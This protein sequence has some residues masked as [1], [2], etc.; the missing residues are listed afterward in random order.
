[1]NA[2][3]KYQ[4]QLMGAAGSVFVGQDSVTL[5]PDRLP[6][7]S[8][9]NPKGNAQS[10]IKSKGRV[11][12]FLRRGSAEKHTPPCTGILGSLWDG[13]QDSEIPEARPREPGRGGGH[14]GLWPCL[15][16]VFLCWAGNG[17][18]AGVAELPQGL[19]CSSGRGHPHLWDGKTPAS[20]MGT[21]PPLGG[22]S[23][24][25]AREIVLLPC[26]LQSSLLERRVDCATP[27]VSSSRGKLSRASFRALFWEGSA[28]S[29]S[30][31]SHL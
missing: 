3:V 8:L 10:V 30:C 13:L 20:G 18:R 7:F 17:A 26:L 28:G 16:S 23:L 14:R 25:T 12:F 21:L 27:K 2:P 15:C 5:S 19:G 11:T 6:P 22:L 31:D 1:M 29:P 24:T 9:N 4:L